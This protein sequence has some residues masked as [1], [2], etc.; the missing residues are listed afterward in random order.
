MTQGAVFWANLEFWVCVC[1][2]DAR[3]SG[4]A[5][6]DDTD[7][8][9]CSVF[10]LSDSGNVVGSEADW[11]Q[12]ETWFFY[13]VPRTNLHR[14]RL[15]SGVFSLATSGISSLWSGCRFGSRPPPPPAPA[16][17]PSRLSFLHPLGRGAARDCANLANKLTLEP[18][19]RGGWSHRCCPVPS[20][21]W[22]A[23]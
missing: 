14:G 22:E 15:N 17:R 16:P 8:F 12:R 2:V 4:R 9:S 19:R 23:K 5:A 1:V 18:T 13:K 7:P 20:R 11:L 3:C 6:N 10:L 21:F